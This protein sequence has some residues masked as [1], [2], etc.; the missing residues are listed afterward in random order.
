M[1][2]TPTT[3]NDIR[4]STMPAKTGARGIINLGKYTLDNMLPPVIRLCDDFV[5]AVEKY[6]H[7]TKAT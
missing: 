4:K 5:N 1:S 6:V 7:G 3:L 2:K